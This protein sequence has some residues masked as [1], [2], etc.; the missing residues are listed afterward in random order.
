MK[1]IP[2]VGAVIVT[3]H[4]NSQ[5]LE[6]LLSAIAS[7]VD[8]VVV[9]DNTPVEAHTQWVEE[10][11]CVY[12]ARYLSLE[13]NLG[14]AAAQNRGITTLQEFEVDFFLF[15]D[16]DSEPALDMVLRLLEAH[17]AHQ[18]VDHPIA[19]IGPF[20][21]IPKLQTWIPFYAQSGWQSI[22]H[23]CQSPN[24]CFEVSHLISSGSLVSREAFHV[25]GGM[26][27]SLFVDYVDIEW[28]WRAQSH[29]FRL[30]GC[31][32][33][34]M[35]H[36]L[37]DAPLK[38]FGKQFLTHSPL[39][40][41]YLVRNALL[42]YRLHFIPLSWKCQDALRVTLKILLYSIFL[43][44][45]LAHVQMTYQG[46]VDGIRGRSGQYGSSN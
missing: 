4:P 13:N 5:T 40:H 39:R 44:P 19:A 38:L 20:S 30:L 24:Q 6:K 28:S 33:A 7:Q 32:A 16:Q 10:L 36:D 9:V 35:D 15:L 45:R 34:T 26:D 41:Y 31:C 25:I 17:E 2:R 43:A 23:F 22:K 27:E 3:Y 8:H 14:I 46:L 37:G 42:L 1:R 11:A 18:S 12:R 21:Y 29:G